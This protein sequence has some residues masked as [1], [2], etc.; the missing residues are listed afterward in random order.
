MDESAI[1][2]VLGI[3]GGCIFPV[4]MVTLIVWFKTNEKRR[5]YE[6]QAELYAKAIERGQE[7]PKGLFTDREKP[8]STYL[9]NGVILIAVGIGIALF[10]GFVRFGEGDYEHVLRGVGMGMIPAFIGIAYLVI[11]FITKRREDK[12]AKDD[13]E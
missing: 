1:I 4:I 10:F 11:Y 3:I 12:Q 13:G 5:R 8:T 7:L 6:V 9:N 2:P